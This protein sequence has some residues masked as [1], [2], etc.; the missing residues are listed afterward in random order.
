M[1]IDDYLGGCSRKVSASAM[2]SGVMMSDS[3]RSAMVW[4]SLTV[5][6]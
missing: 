2:C 6:K 1:S 4:A 5:L 3:S